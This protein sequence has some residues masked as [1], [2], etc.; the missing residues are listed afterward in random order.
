VNKPLFSFAVIADTHTRPEEGDLS[1]PWQVNA[2]ANDRCRYVT[3]MLNELRP[4]FVIH[5]GDVVH[6]VPALPTYGSAA[7]AALDMFAELEAEIRFIPGNHDVGDKPFKAMPAAAVNDHGIALYQQY[8]GA[9]F[10]AFDHGDCRFVLINSPVLNSGLAGEREQRTWLE[11]QLANAEGKRVFLFSHYPPYIL[12]QDEP[13]NYDNID[14]P[15]RHWLLSLIETCGVE[16]LFAGHVHNF[17]YHRHGVTDCYLLPATS[18]FRQDYAELFR[19]EAAPEHGHNDAEK[20]GFFMVDVYAEQHIARCLRTNGKTLAA[21]TKLAPR[22]VQQTTLHPRQRQPAPVGVHLRHPWAEVVTFPYNGPMD[23]FLRKRARNDYTLMTLWELGVRKLRVPTSDL[24]QQE[25]RERMRALRGMGHEFTVFCFETPSKA[26]IEALASHS[27]L[28]EV[29]ELIIPWQ[30]AQKLVA[31]LAALE[32]SIPVPI[33]LAKLETSAEKKSEGSRFSHFVSYGFHTSELDLI[34]G[35]LPLRGA[36]DG[37]VFR[38]RFDESPW[39]TLAPIAEFARAHAVSAAVNVRLASENPAEYNQDDKAIANQVAEAMLAAFSAGHCEVFIDTYVDVD[40]GYFPRHGLFDRRYNPRPAS[41]VYRYLQGWLGALES[42]P[43]L[44]EMHQCQG[45]RIGCFKVADID[46]ALLL[47]GAASDTPPALP[48]DGFLDAM[49]DASLI[50]LCRG[51][52]VDA[53][54]ARN[55]EGC[56]GVEPQPSPDSPSLLIGKRCAP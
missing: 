46:A 37:F 50:D 17:F 56:I 7:Q 44:A 28:L 40:R 8:F 35:F 13:P 48:V 24:L 3:A 10:S 32:A 21:N 5:L 15:Q 41:F 22:T 19:I 1:S 47:P 20:L 55:R 12:D 2:L 14:E 45:W 54:I 36:I 27:D 52:V 11:N 31:E 43:E 4:A 25:T 53:R 18:F 26:M 30:D 51:S 49:V 39:E 6:P 16:A 34:E 42:A 23:E 9:P 29:L 33:T 38:L